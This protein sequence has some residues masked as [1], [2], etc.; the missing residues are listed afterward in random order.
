[1][2]LRLAHYS[3]SLRYQTP[4]SN[5][6]HE[7]VDT[8]TK[9][10]QPQTTHRKWRIWYLT[11]KQPAWK[12]FQKQAQRHNI[13]STLRPSLLG[14]VFGHQEL[15]YPVENNHKNLE[16]GLQLWSWNYWAFWQCARFPSLTYPPS[17]VCIGYLP[18]IYPEV[19]LVKPIPCPET[20]PGPTLVRTY[21]WGPQVRPCSGPEGY[22][23][24]CRLQNAIFVLPSFG[25]PLPNAPIVVL[26]SEI[27]RGY[28]ANRSIN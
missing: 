26:D 23:S 27:A 8:T 28:R 21:R 19:V 4:C 2:Q 20:Y 17:R 15:T 24:I 10:Y 5:V 13:H 18:N 1:M 3:V 6:K 9:K 25:A 14:F 12:L 11:A 22:H 16:L 7:I